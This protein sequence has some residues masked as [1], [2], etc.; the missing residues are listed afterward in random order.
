[1]TKIV[2]K[3]QLIWVTGLAGSG[4]STIAKLLSDRLRETRPSVVYLDGDV[5]REAFSGSHGHDIETRRKLAAR[6]S[7]ICKMLVDQGVCVVAA[8]IAMFHDVHAWNRAHIGDYVEIFVDVPIE[9][10]IR[11]DQKQL[12]SRALSG[13][14][15]DV[16]GIDQP[17]EFPENPS[18][19][20]DNHGERSADDSVA[21]IL[22]FLNKA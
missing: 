4:K 22:D 8:F 19:V 11:R 18:L 14:I 15:V 10:L 9:E 1:M 17:A 3:G 2:P 16:V 12:Y 20:V 21:E 5:L 7:R 6:Y 13:E